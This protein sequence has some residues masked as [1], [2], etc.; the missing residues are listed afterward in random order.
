M[1]SKQ[2]IFKSE[3]HKARST[4][5][6]LLFSHHCRK[7]SITDDAIVLVLGPV[8]RI[9]DHLPI[10]S[11]YISDCGC[12]YT[13]LHESDTLCSNNRVQLC[14]ASA[15]GTKI[16]PAQSVPF[17]FTCKHR[18]PI[19]NAPRHCFDN[20]MASMQMRSID[21]LANRQRKQQI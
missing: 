3:E 18:N 8:Y 17:C 11:L 21:C 14:S 7:Q 9:S 19:R 13:A 1:K 20:R 16:N 15:G 10:G 2:W 6:T 12:V 5:I 4:A